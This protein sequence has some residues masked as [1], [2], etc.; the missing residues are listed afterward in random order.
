MEDSKLAR[1]NEL[2]KKSQNEGLTAEEKKEQADLRSEYIKA[3][4]NNL[5]G[6]LNNISLLNPDGTVTELSKKNKQ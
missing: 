6:T 3:V 1:I 4:R 5:R 2:Y